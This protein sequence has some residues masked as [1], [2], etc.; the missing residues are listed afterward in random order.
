MS[1][2]RTGA[3]SATAASGSG[4][5][6]S[7]SYAT[8]ISSRASRAAQGLSATTAATGVPAAWTRASAMI[9]WGGT[10]MSGTSR[11]T[12][13]GARWLTSAP[14]ATVTTP[15][16]R[17]ARSTSTRTIRACAWGE[18]SRATWAHPG[19]RMSST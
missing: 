6:A 19:G 8:S 17:P 15:G 10:R 13:I 12:G 18:R 4:S 14:V 9:G 5:A 16:A 2:N 11:F 7:G 1:G 3:P